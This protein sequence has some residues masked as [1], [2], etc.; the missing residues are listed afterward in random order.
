[1]DGYEP[2][3]EPDCAISFDRTDNTIT[4]ENIKVRYVSVFP[5]VMN[6]L[7]TLMGAGVLGISDSFRFCGFIPSYCLL[8]LVA[9]LSTVA[10]IMVVHLQ[11][12]FSIKS[13]EGM[14]S[15]V[16]GKTASGI[17][18]ISST[19]F[20]IAAMTAYII[21][22]V[23][24]FQSWLEFGGLKIKSNSEQY[25]YLVLIYSI[26]FPVALTIPR[27]V[28]FLSIFSTF[29]IFCLWLF[30]VF[31]I[32]EGVLILPKQ[33]I[34][35]TVYL[36]SINSGFFNALAVYSLT[37]SLAIVVIPIINLS[38]PS[39]NKRSIIVGWTFFLSLLC[40]AIPGIIG[41]LIFGNEVQP[42]LLES[43]P[44]KSVLTIIVRACF[45]VVVN[46]SYP[47]IGM[48]VFST[49]SRQIFKIENPI[50]V[51]GWKRLVMVFLVSLIPVSVAIFLPNVR[52]A[53]AV[54]GALGG[55]LGNFVFP[56]WIWMKSSNRKAFHWTNI[57]CFLFAIFG[58]FSAAIS[59]YESVI[60]A[61][62]QIK[63]PTD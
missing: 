14:T 55:C 12:K 51:T 3:H 57:L 34:H 54:G 50:D 37:F 61:I 56:P 16:L 26:C 18:G 43:F 39:R 27:N 24:T 5:S 33:G 60:D 13:F 17:L 21:I 22:G 1:M 32:Y 19:L 30:I 7:N 10:T 2:I 62:K 31:M 15:R 45:F 35:H 23:K 59:T 63:S 48:T 53:L 8:L 11:F 44:S 6:L 41:Y 38:F 52:P 49:Y 4:M 46:A 20:C 28:S 29:S 42:V 25:K 36:G 58:V 9:S 47:V 40:V